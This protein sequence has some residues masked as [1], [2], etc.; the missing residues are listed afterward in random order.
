M[1]RLLSFL[2]QFYIS[3][4]LYIA[5][6]AFLFILSLFKFTPSYFIYLPLSLALIAIVWSTIQELRGRILGSG[7]F[8]IVATIIALIAGEQ[9][10]IVV[11]LLILLTANYFGL[12]IEERTKNAIES[13]IKLMPEK[14]NVLVDHKEYIKNIADVKPGE[15]VLV[16]TGGRIPVDGLVTEGN[17]AINEAP[18]TGESMPVEK[19]AHDIV[20]AGTFIESGS[21]IIKTQKTGKGT[22]L[23]KIGQLIKQAEKNKAPIVVLS[24]KIAFYVTI[25]FIV[26]IAAVWLYT[27]D[28]TMIVT[29]LV[30]G[31]PL[32]LTLA[33]PLTIL[34]AI[35]SAFA[36]GVIIKG[37]YSL[38]QCAN[39][40]TMIFDKTGTLTLGEPRVVDIHVYDIKF[41]K[42]DIIKYAAI[43][44][45]RSGHVLAKAILKKAADEGINVPD[46]TDYLSL[47]GHGIE[48]SYDGNHYLLGN[49]HFIEA[50]EHG[51]IPLASIAINKEERSTVIYLAQNNKIIGALCIQDEIRQDAQET[52]KKLKKQGIKLMMILSGDRQAIANQVAAK[53]NINKAYGE[54]M[55]E[56]KLKIISQLQK[57]GHVV[58]MVGDGINDAP[59]L[60]HASVGFAMGAMGMEPAIEAADI[61]LMANNL[62]LLV[63]VRTLSRKSLTIIKQNIIWGLVVTH[64]IGIF[65]GLMQ[66]LNPIQ[67]ALFH[68]IPELIIFI[69]SA[70]LLLFKTANRYRIK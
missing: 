29:L 21:L 61:V 50:P 37:G 53:L 54:I 66:L 40:D 20:F 11:V 31:S 28:L 62:E 70:R 5:L 12:L 19:T 46:P 8:F 69:N 49:R 59:A 51:N 7:P 67:A 10:A 55:P 44:E 30:F 34:A 47:T 45:K 42:Q 65:L 39:T 23:G 18:L 32:E 33:A 56:E 4:L 58:G 36:N 6:I 48:I 35:A 22:E 41:T 3:Y 63:F 27:R 1:L 13:L 14:V 60:K 9:R 26:F 25:F 38:E 2:K 43:A 17:A 15:I 24:N 64:T 68:A 16:K 57:E 52:I